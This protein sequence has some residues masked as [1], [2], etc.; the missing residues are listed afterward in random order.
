M[1]GKK[2]VVIMKAL[3]MENYDHVLIGDLEHSLSL[4]ETGTTPILIYNGST[5]TYSTIRLERHIVPIGDDH[6]DAFAYVL[7]PGRHSYLELAD[8]VRAVDLALADDGQ[9]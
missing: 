4:E 1:D 9:E 8:A 7:S 5:G 2:E 6:E 3:G